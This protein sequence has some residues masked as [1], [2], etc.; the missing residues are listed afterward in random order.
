MIGHGH[1]TPNQSGA[2][3]RCGGPAI[4]EDCWAE[5]MALPPHDRGVYFKRNGWSLTD[6]NEAKRRH[7][8]Y[9][10]SHHSE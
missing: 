8:E 9:P 10:I 6:V 2:V 5:L 7:E 1:V 4:C 3:A